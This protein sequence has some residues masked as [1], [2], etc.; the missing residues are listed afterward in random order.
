MDVLRAR[1]QASEEL[2]GETLG[3]LERLELYL[4]SAGMENSGNATHDK[5][6]AGAA[7]DASL[8]GDRLERLERFAA[9]Q[10]AVLS[11]SSLEGADSTVQRVIALE[12]ALQSLSADGPVDALQ[13]LVEQLREQL[14][15]SFANRAA[16][17]GESEK[18]RSESEA[19]Q[20]DAAAFQG[21]VE[22]A[23]QECVVLRERL[24]DS[25][26]EASGA[27][28]TAREVE[29]L[30]ARLAE[31]TAQASMLSSQLMA[32][33]ADVAQLERRLAD[34]G[35]WGGVIGCK[36][37]PNLGGSARRHEV[38]ASPVTELRTATPQG[39]SARN[40]MQVP[41][42]I[43]VPDSAAD[44]MGSTTTLWPHWDPSLPRAQ[45]QAS[46]WG[47]WTPPPGG[48]LRDLNLQ[49]NRTRSPVSARSM[50]VQTTSSTSFSSPTEPLA[51][52]QRKAR[53]VSIS[54]NKELP[55]LRAPS[56]QTP[57]LQPASPI[58]RVASVAPPPR[59]QSVPVQVRQAS[60]G[61]AAAPA[62]CLANWAGLPGSGMADGR[63]QGLTAQ[64]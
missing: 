5:R 44:S 45:P 9:S 56:P 62:V 17:A 18:W 31:S 59:S 52:V 28:A 33:D 41:Y 34:S 53:L 16:M 36:G 64:W 54:S 37:D 2:R 26:R 14:T 55:H 21:E 47:P 63:N 42:N 30:R 24:A 12:S 49:N 15:A 35:R 11:R 8:L 23:E 48:G 32:R 46:A 13:K 19:L 40:N 22:S 58:Q 29:A 25:A 4:S 38:S 60:P 3:R 43:Q 6:V 57:H 10:G 51:T 61:G 27:A 1:L 20:R 39:E 50:Q 7:T